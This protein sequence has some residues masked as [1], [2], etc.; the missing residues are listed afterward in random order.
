[1]ALAEPVRNPF[2]HR[3][4][5]AADKADGQVEVLGRGPAKFGRHRSAGDEVP[6]KFLDL[7]LRHRQP[8][9]GTDLQRLGGFFQ[10]IG[11]HVL[12]AVGRQPKLELT[13]SM[14]AA[15]FASWPVR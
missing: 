7:G 6:I 13:E 5:D 1:M 10:W 14:P 4:L 11:A 12:G 3:T 9:E 2:D 15:M 8:K